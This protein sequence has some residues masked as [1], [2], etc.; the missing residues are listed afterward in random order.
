MWPSGFSGVPG[1]FWNQR[2]LLRIALPVLLLVVVWTLKSPPDSAADNPG[3]LDSGFLMGLLQSWENGREGDLNGDG[4]TDYRD[5]LLL[6]VFWYGPPLSPSPT[7]S[8]T[9]GLSATPSRTPTVTSTPSPT[10]TDLVSV[11][12]SFRVIPLIKD[13]YLS[14]ASP[15]AINGH[16]EELRIRE[17]GDNQTMVALLRFD[18]SDLATDTEVMG[19]YL[20]LLP[21]GNPSTQNCW[22]EIYEALGEWEEDQTNWQTRP[23]WPQNALTTVPAPE[24]PGLE[25]FVDL[26]SIVRAWIKGEKTNYGLVLKIPSN[27]AGRCQFIFGSRESA[28]P[29]TLNLAYSVPARPTSPLQRPTPTAIPPAYSEVVLSPTG[30]GY[31]RWNGYETYDRNFPDPGA[32][33]LSHDLVQPLIEGGLLGFDLSAIPSRSEIFQ[34]SL[35]LYL[36]AGENPEPIAIRANMMDTPWSQDRVTWASVQGASNRE[37]DAPR[38]YAVVGTDPG[39]K[40]MDVTRILRRWMRNP[41]WVFGFYLLGSDSSQGP[42]MRRFSGC[43]ARRTQPRL[44]IRYGPRLREK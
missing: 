13:T 5:V 44:I 6:S 32:L 36:E 28:S 42:W 24:N 11:S 17:G 37:T 20:T 41:D 7:V 34:A 19:A 15:S 18:L 26:T 21:S 1:L 4:T 30:C 3:S 16:L 43:G 39:W 2:F 23:P 40:S 31:V 35:E 29:P 22:L 8:F 9:A 33:I 25:T 27:Q 10:A 14:S 12:N 38:G